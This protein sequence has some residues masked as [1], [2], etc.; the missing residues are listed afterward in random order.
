MIKH[1][2]ECVGCPMG[3]KGNTCSDLN[4]PHVYCD[5]CGNEE[6]VYYD[7]EGEWLC[8]ECYIETMLAIA[9]TATSKE[10]I[11]KDG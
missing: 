7:Y 8:K 11:E 6:E 10:I 3:C 1:E 4:A 5:G 9:E 2:N